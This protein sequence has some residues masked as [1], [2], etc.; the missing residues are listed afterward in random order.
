MFQNHIQK[1]VGNSYF[2]KLYNQLST[3]LDYCGAI[4]PFPCEWNTRS[5]CFKVTQSHSRKFHSIKT[6]I[7]ILALF[8][9]MIFTTLHLMISTEG[10]YVKIFAFDVAIF[11]GMITRTQLF[12]S[13]HDY[14]EKVVA[15][16]NSLKDLSGLTYDDDSYKLVSYL[17]SKFHWVS[18]L[19]SF[20]IFVLLLVAPNIPPFPGYW[21][22]PLLQ[23]KLNHHSAN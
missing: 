15:F 6:N 14:I 2:H 8:I 20:G 5:N 9:Q 11:T 18:L 17:L 21:L 13:S 16:K 1:Y 3:Q 7:F 12:H 10:L 22:L 23:L 19:V 4:I